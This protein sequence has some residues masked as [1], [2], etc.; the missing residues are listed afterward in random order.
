M[1]LSDPGC[2][3]WA[4]SEGVAFSFFLFFFFLINGNKIQEELSPSPECD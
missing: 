1:L 3:E 2:E 4:G